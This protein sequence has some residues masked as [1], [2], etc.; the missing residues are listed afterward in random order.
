[1]LGVFTF[2]LTHLLA[3]SIFPEVMGG[4]QNSNGNSRGVRGWVFLVVEKWKFQGGGGLTCTWHSL[5]GVAMEWSR[6]F[7]EL[8]IVN[9]R[10]DTQIY[11]LC[12]E[13][14]NASRQLVIIFKTNWCQFLMCLSYYRQWILSQHGYG[15]VDPQLLWHCYDKIH[16]Q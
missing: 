4:V 5:R 6:Y 14:T 3:K 9:K 7:L 15:L 16:N 2:T 13:S 11:N 8:H 1:M 10:T 12:H